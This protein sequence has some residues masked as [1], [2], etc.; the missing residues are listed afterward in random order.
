[1]LFGIYAGAAFQELAGWLGMVKNHLSPVF[2]TS[3]VPKKWRDPGL[4]ANSPF[5]MKE[6]LAVLPTWVF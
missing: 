2:E 3:E 5:A 6:E 1:M 4:C